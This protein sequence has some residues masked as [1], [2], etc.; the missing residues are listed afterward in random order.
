MVK[1][2]NI[3][4]KPAVRKAAEELTREFVVVQWELQ[5]NDV[6]L[7]EYFYDSIEQQLEEKY[8]IKYSFPSLDG[9][10][11]H[12]KN[13]MNVLQ[14]IKEKDSSRGLVVVVDEISDFLKQKT[15]EKI[16]RDVQFLRIVGQTAQENDFT[17]IGAMQEHIFSNPK[18]IDEADSIGRVHERF[19]IITIKRDDIKKVIAYRVLN[20]TR[21]QRAIA[22]IN[23]W[24]LTENKPLVYKASNILSDKNKPMHSYFCQ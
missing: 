19:Q 9:P 10:V 13:I 17:F 18:Y 4:P 24:I 6:S 23:R 8:G 2:N 14:V 12:K 3:V 5:P 11:D 1:S 7:A 16:T 15:K 22:S 20:K 21:E